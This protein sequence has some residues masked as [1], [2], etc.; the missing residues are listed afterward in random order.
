MYL[1]ISNT[2]R[3]ANWARSF[4]TGSF[5]NLRILKLSGLRLTDKQFPTMVLAKCSLRLWSLDVRDNLLR[6]SFLEELNRYAFPEYDIRLQFPIRAVVSASDEELYESVAFYCKDAGHDQFP[7]YNSLVGM[8]Y[9][10]LDRFKKHLL[11]EADLKAD[12]ARCL[13]LDDKNTQVTGLTH[14]YLSDNKFTWPFVRALISMYNI[15]L[16]V[17]DVGSPQIPVTVDGW[18]SFIMPY[19]LTFAAPHCAQ[20]LHRKSGSR[21]QRLRINHS[22]VTQVP[23][24]TY[25]SSRPGFRWDC[26]K[27]AEKV[28]QETE[29]IWGPLFMPQDNYMIS[30]LSLTDIPTHS[31]GTII[32]RLIEF[33]RQCHAQEVRLAAARASQHNHRAPPLLSGLRYLRL[34]FIDPHPDTFFVPSPSSPNTLSVSGDKDADTFMASGSNDFSFFPETPTHRPPRR[35]SS[36]TLGKGT[37]VTRDEDELTEPKNVIQELK[38]FRQIV[39]RWSGTLQIVRHTSSQSVVLE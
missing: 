9:D 35:G 15:R 8:R 20:L 6:D 13:P 2:H 33:L 25:L 29:Q 12:P 31:Y 17:L 7:P 11:T 32:E 1:D 4:Q 19:S 18:S 34:E 14:L 16:Q 5:Q 30:S 36:Q 38:K 23:T 27:R 39:P 26:L 3:G 28:D 37:E 10:D 22:L 24:I 21:I